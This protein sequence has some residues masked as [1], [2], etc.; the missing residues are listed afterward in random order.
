MKLVCVNTNVI[1]SITFPCSVEIRILNKHLDQIVMTVC[2]MQIL[3]VFF[4]PK[5]Y[6]QSDKVLASL[7]SRR[8][9]SK[10]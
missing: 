2:F 3:E 5:F 9:Y 8:E 1:F 10:T 7:D 6:S 4:F